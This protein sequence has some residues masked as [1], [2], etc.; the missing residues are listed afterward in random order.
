[1]YFTLQCDWSKKIASQPIRCKI[2]TK[3][4]SS[5]AFCR[6]VGSW[7]VF[8]LNSHLP[9]VLFICSLIGRCEDCGF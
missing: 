1:M 5:L 2:L 9:F 6:V 8:A 7:K 3:G 4:Y